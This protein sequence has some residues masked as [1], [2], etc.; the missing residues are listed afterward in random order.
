[1]KL[2][3]INAFYVF[4]HRHYSFP[5]CVD[6]TYVQ[7]KSSGSAI[8]GISYANNRTSIPDLGIES[9]SLSVN[10]KLLSLGAGYGYTLMPGGRWQIMLMAMPKLVFYD[11]SSLKNENYSIYRTF[12]RPQFMFTGHAAAVH[13]FGRN[14]LALT[15][16]VEGYRVGNISGFKL[17]QYQWSLRLHYGILF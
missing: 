3:N 15:S 14:F 5:A 11:S 13:W 1:M 17:F 16:A 9:A 6:Q 7:H 4:N 10:A 12:T 8:V 2:L